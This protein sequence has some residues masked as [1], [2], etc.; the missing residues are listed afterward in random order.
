M[1]SMKVLQKRRVILHILSIAIYFFKLKKSVSGNG[2][3]SKLL[4]QTEA[5]MHF[6]RN[7]KS[8]CTV[9]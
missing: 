6:A 3:F 8:A 7:R 2:P 5:Y 9:R 1:N 4:A